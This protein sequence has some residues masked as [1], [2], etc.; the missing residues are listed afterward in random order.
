MSKRTKVPFWASFKRK[1]KS[2]MIIL[3]VVTQRIFCALKWSQSGQPHLLSSVLPQS[4]GISFISSAERRKC[5]IWCRNE[6]GNLFKASESM[7]LLSLWGIEIE[8]FFLFS[9]LPLFS[10]SFFGN[11]K[12]L[13]IVPI[14][15]FIQI[16]YSPII[17][18]VC[19]SLS[20]IAVNQ[21][22]QM[23]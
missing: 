9:F 13:S 22:Q 14:S 19:L 1:R 16:D 11:T 17:S 12:I 15:L 20:L 23:T 2:H 8:S 21:R 5:R 18:D 3:Q 4:L 6:W 7:K 10:F